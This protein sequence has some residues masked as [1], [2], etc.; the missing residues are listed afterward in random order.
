MQVT[1]MENPP[2][3]YLQEV[4]LSFGA[5]FYEELF[6][7]LI[8]FQVFILIAKAFQKDPNRWNVRLIIIIVGAL[9]FSMVHYI[10]TYGDNFRFNSFL[11]RFFFGLIMYPIFIY[12]GLGIAA[13]SHA[14]YDV[15]VFTMRRMN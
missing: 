15:M 13:W 2:T 11:Q 6:F 7:R 8:L 4:V 1:K 12:R 14:L 3:Y 10:G 5:G 9:L